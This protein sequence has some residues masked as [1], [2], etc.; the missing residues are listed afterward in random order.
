MCGGRKYGDRT[1]L[2][3]TLDEISP[4]EVVHGGASGADRIAGYWAELRGVPCTVYPAEWG[5]YGRKAGPIRNLH[6]LKDS[7]PDMVVA[8]PGGRGTAHMIATA[9]S[10]GVPVKVVP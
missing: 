10:H 1:T 7:Q 2:F 5:R 9:R 8:F 4:T 3:R 6:M